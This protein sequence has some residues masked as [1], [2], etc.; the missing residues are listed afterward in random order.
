MPEG[1]THACIALRA[2]ADAG[3]TITDRAAFLAGA[4]G[5]DM[6]YCFEAWKPAVRRRYD[7]AGFGRRMHAER[8]G[9]FLRALRREAVTAPQKDYF[10]G[11]LCHYAADT[12]VHPYV[13]AV[14][15]CCPP[16]AGRSGHGRFEAALDTYLHK[17]DTG[18]G[19]VPV[20]DMCPLLTG[21]PLAAVTAQLQNAIGAVYDTDIPREFLADAFFDN[22]RIRR[23]FCCR[24]PLQKQLLCLVQPF[25]GGRGTISCHLTPARLRGVSRRDTRRGV[26]LPAI[27]RDPA[28]GAVREE[29]LQQVLDAAQRYASLLVQEAAA[30]DT[31]ADLFWPLVGSRDYVTGTETPRSSAPAA[32]GQNAAKTPA[33]PKTAGAAASAAGQTPAAAE[34]Q[35]PPAAAGAAEEAEAYAE[36]E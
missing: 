34:T 12:V 36:A 21:V 14:T 23:L 32:A 31:G 15:K 22:H 24:L 25:T 29:N 10:L 20:D 2:A 7:L 5:P 4:N 13:Q 19:A 16:Y 17:R 3:W 30:P 26:S 28:T 11:F 33:P 1:Y 35:A 18:R 9:A 6:L 8:T 27:W